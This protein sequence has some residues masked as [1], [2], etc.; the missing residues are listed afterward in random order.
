MNDERMRVYL[1]DG[2]EIIAATDDMVA[3]YRNG[4]MMPKNAKIMSMRMAPPKVMPTQIV[5]HRWP[6]ATV[7]FWIGVCSVLYSHWNGIGLICMGVAYWIVNRIAKNTANEI[8]RVQSSS[9]RSVRSSGG[10]PAVDAEA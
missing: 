2:D 6:V 9:K 7:M 4:D 10:T 5:Q 3:T 8:A 1:R